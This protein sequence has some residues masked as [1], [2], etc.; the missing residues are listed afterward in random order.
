[1]KAI[2][3]T[4][5]GVAYTDAPEPIPSADQVLIKVRA[6]ALNRAD[7]AVASG[8]KHGSVGG[9]GTIVGMESAGDVLAVGANVDHVAPGDRVMCAGGAAFAELAVADR[10]RVQKIPGANVSYATAA[11][12]PVALN[13]MHNAIVTRGRLSAGE[14]ILIQGASSGV[15]LLGM[16]IARHMGAKLVIGT[17]THAGRRA[18]LSEYGADLALDTTSPDWADQVLAATDG[19]GVDLIVDQVSASVANENMRATKITGRIVNVGR[20]GGACGSF[21]FNLHALR[22]IEYIGVTFRTRSVEEVREIGRLMHADLWD[23]VETGKLSLPIDKTFPLSE[24]AQALAHMEANQHFGKI[25]L[26]TD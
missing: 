2:V 25:V 3:V 13:T 14:S 17:S 5:T 15:G 16:Q 12:L 22:R 8:A 4:S 21:D 1:M 7:L 6:A 26:S 11:T 10:G 19:V 18:R 20:L 23:A 9:P 24:G